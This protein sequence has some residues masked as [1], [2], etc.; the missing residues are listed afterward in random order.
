[1]LFSVNRVKL[2]GPQYKEI[3]NE[4]KTENPDGNDAMMTLFKQIYEKGDEQ[5]KAAMKKSFS[6]SGG[7]VLSTNWDEV[8]AKDYEGRDRPE[9]PKGQEWSK[10]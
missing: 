9:P 4:L 6:T 8:K 3:D 10:N 7:T 1:M 2:F 5:T